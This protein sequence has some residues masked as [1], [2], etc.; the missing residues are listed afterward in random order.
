M[1]GH[2]FCYQCVS[3]YITGDDND[4]PANNCKEQLGEDVVFSKITLRSCIS[5]DLGGSPTHSQLPDT[6]A[7]LQNDFVS[8]KIKAV[9]EILQSQ[10]V[11]NSSISESQGFTDGNVMSEGFVANKHTTVHSNSP[12]DGPIKTIVFSQWTRM[13]DL[14]EF[15]MNQHGIQYRRLDG[16]MSLASRDRA[17]KDFN[18]DSQV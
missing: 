17:V 3:E 13:L 9:L 14:V 15:S 7:V 4:C 10:C 8:A 5:D 2:V 18:N 16:T 11:H 6:L 1:C 12:T